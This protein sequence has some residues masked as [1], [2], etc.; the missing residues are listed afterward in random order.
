MTWLDD[1]ILVELLNRD[2][3]SL[4]RKKAVKS[5]FKSSFNCLIN[6]SRLHNHLFL[7][8]MTLLGLLCREE[9]IHSM[10]CNQGSAVKL[11][12][13]SIKIPVGCAK[14]KRNENHYLLRTGNLHSTPNSMIFHSCL[15]PF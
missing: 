11:C 2:S 1:V 3:H 12:Q 5:Q 10:R 9:V 6:S 15:K 14:K 13:I 8:S 7:A 4:K